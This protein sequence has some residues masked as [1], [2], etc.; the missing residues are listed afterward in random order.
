MKENYVEPDIS[1]YAAY[2]GMTSEQAENYLCSVADIPEE[3][4]AAWRDAL[5]RVVG[6]FRNENVDTIN[7][8]EKEKEQ[9]GKMAK[10]FGLTDDD[11]LAMVAMGKQML[12]REKKDIGQER[13]GADATDTDGLEGE[14]QDIL[15]IDEN[16]PQDVIDLYRDA[17]N[18]EWNPRTNN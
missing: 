6:Q 13:A 1:A 5:H 3:E 14:L 16:L 9:I 11:A 12:T 2:F 10:A 15:G 4:M 7:V 8:S 17:K 18:G